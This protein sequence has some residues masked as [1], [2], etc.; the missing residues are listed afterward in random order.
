MS[1]EM[2][3]WLLLIGESVTSFTL[4]L[5][6]LYIVFMLFDKKGTGIGVINFQGH[7]LMTIGVLYIVFGFILARLTRMPGLP[8]NLPH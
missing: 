8:R 5:L 4:S 1:P 2:R 7:I 3:G 6:V